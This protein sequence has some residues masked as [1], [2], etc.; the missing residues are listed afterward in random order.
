MR[1]WSKAHITTGMLQN[2]VALAQEG[3]NSLVLSSFLF[4]Y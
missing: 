1:K 3:D 4:T 2:A